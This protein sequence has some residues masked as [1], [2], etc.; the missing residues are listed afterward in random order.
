M[1]IKIAQTSAP[2]TNYLLGTVSSYNS[3]TGDLVVDV[4][5]VVGSGTYTD[6]SIS[7]QSGATVSAA[8]YDIGENAY[9]RNVTLDDLPK[10]IG[11]FGFSQVNTALAYNATYHDLTALTALKVKPFLYGTEKAQ[12]T[13]VNVFGDT[14]QWDYGSTRYAY[15]PNAGGI[16]YSTDLITWTVSNVTTGS[17]KIA[18]NGTLFVAYTISTAVSYTSTDGITWTP[19][20]CI[21]LAAANKVVWGAGL[22]VVINGQNTTYA[23]SPDGQTWTSRTL[24]ASVGNSHL[25]FVNSVFVLSGIS[26]Q[27][28]TSTDGINWTSRVS[29]QTAILQSCAYFSGKY[30]VGINGS[31]T[32]I[33]SPDLVTWTEKFNLPVPS[34]NETFQVFTTPTEMY[35][36]ANS[37]LTI[38]TTDG[39]T[40][41]IVGFGSSTNNF[42][43]QYKWANSKL[44]TFGEGKILGTSGIVDYGS[45]PFS[46]T[47]RGLYF[48][49]ATTMIRTK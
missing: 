24:P 38:K 25:S 27:I 2:N 34:G 33:S 40:F 29:G 21:S 19:R 23:T 48:S 18:H 1:A 14:S 28:Y 4:A 13:F 9:S 17:Y 44:I 7:L 15:S 35:L 30:W 37:G 26:G 11:S 42:P 31:G 16:Y 45:T 43:A 22:F 10:T 39:T 20:T 8:Q 32:V 5:S 46:G 41:T 12:S 6:W 3:G 36:V 49:T 47:I